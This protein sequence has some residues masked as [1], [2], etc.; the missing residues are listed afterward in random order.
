MRQ[1]GMKPKS[2]DSGVYWI[3]AN[4]GNDVSNN[5]D[6]FTGGFIL[7]ITILSSIALVALGFIDKY[8]F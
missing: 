3:R 2:H 6:G 1:G 7:L 4:G 8:F 5:D